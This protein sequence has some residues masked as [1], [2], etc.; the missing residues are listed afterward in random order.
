MKMEKRGC[1]ATLYVES[2]NVMIPKRLRDRVMPR[3]PRELGTAVGH[4]FFGLTDEKG[5]EKTYGLHAAC[6]SLGHENVTPENRMTSLFSF[7]RIAGLVTDEKGEPYDDKIVYH[8]SREQFDAVHDYAE[9]ARKEPPKYNIWTNNC[10]TF[11]YKALKKAGVRLPPQLPFC[12]PAMT[13]V[14]I[15]ALEKA[16]RIKNSL[17]Q[18]AG[19]LADS[20][21]SERK[22]SADG[23]ARLKK[24]PRMEGFGV[25]TLTARRVKER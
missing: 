19:Q 16:D 4:V 5:V 15:R 20:F 22:V 3:D 1:K 12:T 14:G 9:K 10:T 25:K 11:A 6:C 21:S 24:Q 8:I 18:A 23:L 13:V 2:P 7:R 17:I